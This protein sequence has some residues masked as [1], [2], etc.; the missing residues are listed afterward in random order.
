M[1]SL[2]TTADHTAPKAAP[3]AHAGHFNVYEIEPFT[4]QPKGPLPYDKRDFYKVTVLEGT[5]RMM[6]ADR[7]VE[8]GKQALI[9]SNPY[10]PYCWKH[11]ESEHK[12]H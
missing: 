3:I 5:S 1:P 6:Y 12:G 11:F 8:I 7:E 2:T 9:F 10:E 4:E